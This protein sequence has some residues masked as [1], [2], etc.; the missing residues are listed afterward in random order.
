LRKESFSSLA[1]F[2]ASLLAFPQVRDEYFSFFHTFFHNCEKTT[3]VMKKHWLHCVSIFHHFRL[4]SWL[5]VLP[6]GLFRLFRRFFHRFSFSPV[7]KSVNFT[8]WLLSGGTM[9]DADS[10]ARIAVYDNLLAS[11]RIVDVPPA[12]LQDHI[13]HIAAQAYDLSHA[14]GGSLPYMVIREIAENFIHAGFRECTVSILDGGNTLSFSDQGPG[15]TRKDLVIKPGFTSATTDMKRYIRGVGSGLPIA[16]EYLQ[17]VNG[18]L[19][20]EDNAVKG[21]VV[22]VSVAQQLAP[23]AYPQPAVGVAGMAD[24]SYPQPAQQ[25]LTTHASPASAE[26]IR[27]AEAAEA[28][29]VPYSL[30]DQQTLPAQK[31]ALPLTHPPETGWSPQLAGAPPQHPVTTTS[32]HPVT[33]PSP[34][35]VGPAPQQ[36]AAAPP[37]QLVATTPQLAAL[38]TQPVTPQQ[39]A[40]PVRLKPREEAVLQL[41]FEKGVIGSGDL[42]EPLQISAPTATRLLQDLESYGYVEVA[43]RRKRVLSNA[44]LAYI[45]NML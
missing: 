29:T 21:T 44:G 13:D 9:T 1:G 25:G 32:P 6:A 27:A 2:I 26:P 10:G 45:Q 43:A 42:V 5:P 33:T 40:A 24:P 22:T 4:F 31:R 19:S 8:L 18:S 39:P 23:A 15:I 11:P 36:L 28:A 30:A 7:E 38:Q 14:Q 3:A 17:T 35:P 34:H 16:R 20:I 41:L 12:P 37:Q